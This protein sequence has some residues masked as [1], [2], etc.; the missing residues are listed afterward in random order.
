MGNLNDLIYDFLTKSK[1]DVY[2]KEIMINRICKYFSISE[3]AAIEGYSNWRRAYMKTKGLDINLE[4]DGYKELY[5]E[6]VK[7]YREE[8]KTIKEIANLLSM[9]TS[10]VVQILDEELKGVC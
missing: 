2:E 3:K 9:Y 7:K 5:L 1:A 6:K 4:S 10:T 8:N